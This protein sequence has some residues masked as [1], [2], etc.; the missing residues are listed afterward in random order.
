MSR[1]DDAR[2]GTAGRFDVPRRGMARRPEG[3]PKMCA[4]Q[5][6]G[7]TTTIG[8]LLSVPLSVV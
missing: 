2:Q 8:G 5:H 6:S 7:T 3:A 4:I 1:P